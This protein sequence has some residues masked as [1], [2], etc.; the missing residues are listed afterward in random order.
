ME[1]ENMI[2]IIFYLGCLFLICFAV[3]LTI[4][5]CILIF[6]FFLRFKRT[7]KIFRN[8][9]L[10][11]DIKELNEDEWFRL[12]LDI[13]RARQKQKDTKSNTK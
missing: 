9:I 13:Q 8:I 4:G 2:D 5:I 12:Q 11:N 6:T 1:K 10:F 3:F 7:R